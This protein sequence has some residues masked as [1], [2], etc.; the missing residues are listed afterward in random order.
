[1]PI[2][3]ELKTHFVNLLRAQRAFNI[4][5]AAALKPETL[6]PKR[7]W[8]RWDTAR[9]TS[10]LLQTNYAAIKDYLLNNQSIIDNMFL[11]RISQK[12]DNGEIL[13][14]GELRFLYIPSPNFI[15]RGITRRRDH[16]QDL[17]RLCECAPE[18]ISLTR[19]E[20]LRGNIKYHY[21]D[22]NLSDLSTDLFL[23]EIISGKLVLGHETLNGNVIFP[24]LIQGNLWLDHVQSATNQ[25]FSTV[26]E[27]SLSLS[28]LISATNLVLPNSVGWDLQLDSLESV[29]NVK[30]PQQVGHDCWLGFSSD[31]C[32]KEVT[33]PQEINGNLNLY[34]LRSAQ[35]LIFPTNFRISG[36]VKLPRFSDY[37]L[38]SLKQRYPHLADKIRKL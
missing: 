18:E 34:N 25:I 23:P 5:Y 30:L 37:E 24:K 32:F 12:N 21:G 33:L 11:D 8:R 19:E 15:I 2:C 20:A 22:L 35:K 7:P 31:E 27:G 36:I 38:N 29:S 9:E 14:K 16:R 3:A 6:D 26:V 4:A 17:S 13:T 28:N 10:K 1:M